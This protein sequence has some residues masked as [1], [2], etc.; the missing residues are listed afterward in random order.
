MGAARGGVSASALRQGEDQLGACEQA[1]F[2][3]HVILLMFVLS[4]VAPV[5][6]Q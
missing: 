1:A 5:A 4:F 3:S 2:W 6:V